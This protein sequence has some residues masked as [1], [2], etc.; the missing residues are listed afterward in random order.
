MS[1][2][3]DEHE[4]R[5]LRARLPDRDLVGQRQAESRFDQTSKFVQRLLGNDLDVARIVRKPPREKNLARD[6]AE[7]RLEDRSLS[8]FSGLREV[9]DHIAVGQGLW[10]EH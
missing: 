6:A 5:R 10:S 4:A 7:D 8:T 3:V 1:E 9:A 2:L